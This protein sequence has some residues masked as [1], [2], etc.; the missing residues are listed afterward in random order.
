MCGE[1]LGDFGTGVGRDTLEEVVGA[2]AVVIAGVIAGAI[3]GVIADVS[4]IAGAIAGAI[5]VVVIV[6]GG[7]VD[8]NWPF[9]RC[10]G[11]RVVI[12]TGSRLKLKD[13]V[14]DSRG[15]GLMPGV[16]LS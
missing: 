10:T 4:M 12:N 5:A 3:A 15:L 2:I 1:R 8:N 11:A 6:V 14:V 13:T 16:S 9:G 7:G